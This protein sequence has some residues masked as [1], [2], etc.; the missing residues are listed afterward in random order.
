MSVEIT[1]REDARRKLMAGME[2]LAGVIAA[3]LGP[4]GRSAVVQTAAGPL[5]TSSPAAI[6]KDFALEDPMENMG[7]QLIR[8]A[9]AKTEDLV[10]GGAASSAVLTRCMVREG[11][12][13]IAA[14][15]NPVE[16]RKGL[17]GAAQ[18]AS[19]AIK[20]IAKPAD[21]RAVVAD[22]AS[23]SAGDPAIGALVAEALE[24]VG[25]DGAV[26]VEE[27]GGRD[28]VLHVEEGVQFE[29]GLLSPHMATDRERMT[30]ELKNPYILVTDKKI[31]SVQDLLPILEQ[32]REQSR[33]LLI[34]ADSVEGEALGILAVNVRNGTLR[35]AAVA[36]PAYGDGRRARLED[37]AVLTG[38]EL[39]S[40]ELGRSLQD[41]TTN[42]L[43]TAAFVR[44]DRKTTVITGGGG[45]RE[46]VAEW[47]AGLR[48]RLSN[49][50]YDFDRRQLEERLSKITGGAAA[51]RV[52]A[53][54]EV[55]L[56]E[57]KRHIEA[58]LRIA[59]AARAEGVV[60]GGGA[61]L[62][63]IAPTV[64]A[65]ADA[66]SG[67]RRTGAMIVLGAL[68][69]PARQ[70]AENS[71]FDP[72]AALAEIRRRGAG[73]GLDVRTGEY[74]DM[75]AAG[76]ADPAR[77]VRFALLHAASTAAVLLTSE[78]G[79]AGIPPVRQ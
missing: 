51:I 41:V 13:N 29:R 4:T 67:D 61:A 1:F 21:T 76:I 10:G 54:T 12:R 47:A 24:R 45:N 65:C 44:V 49:T 57:K 59:R 39:I 27:S 48:A 16:L 36:A 35:A 5:I 30:A 3:A 62:V 31:T 75:L 73:T 42:M 70:I 7:A 66:L 63:N 40:E 71:G 23:V 28:A 68:E 72:G 37:L 53:A 64:R 26:T 2:Q 34:I 22:A 58:A 55:E 11:F 8:E 20:R 79:V 19:A 17:Q 18:A 43:G 14:G 15:A 77:A 32:V 6:A 56:K 60:P 52:G 38:G 25:R 74:A 50:N 78:A 46:A 9:V 33:S 69:A